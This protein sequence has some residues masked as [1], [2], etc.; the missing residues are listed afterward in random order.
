[1]KL[2]YENKKSKEKKIKEI[3][4]NIKQKEHELKKN[5]RET[6]I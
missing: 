6:K 2:N 3:Q 5:T 4:E 1:M